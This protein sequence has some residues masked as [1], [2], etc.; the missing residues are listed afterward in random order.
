MTSRNLLLI[1]FLL[2]AR[3]GIAQGSY[4]QVRESMSEVRQVYTDAVA[5]GQHVDLKNG[6]YFAIGAGLGQPYGCYGFKL[7]GRFSETMGTVGLSAGLGLSPTGN[8]KYEDVSSA[9]FWTLGL[10]FYIE[11]FYIDIQ[12]GRIARIEYKPDEKNILG[13]GFLIGYNWFFNHN[14]GIN[15]S[16]GWIVPFG[17]D[18]DDDHKYAANN[19]ELLNERFA[20]F[21]WGIGLLYRIPY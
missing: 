9:T 6:R 5:A 4:D 12:F 21:D 1:I 15:L 18:I 11:H 19:Y 20:H 10:Q 7:L 3:I 2:S 13:A 8:N 17:Y 16:L 14:W